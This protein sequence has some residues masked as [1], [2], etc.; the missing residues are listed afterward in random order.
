MNRRRHRGRHE[1][2]RRRSVGIEG[3]APTTTEIPCEQLLAVR[4]S[5][6]TASTHAPYQYVPSTTGTGTVEFSRE[7][8]PGLNLDTLTDATSTSTGVIVA[9]VDRYKRSVVRE[10]LLP[11]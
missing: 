9:S 10:A 1:R 5:P 6:F 2:Q 4:D 8:A 7:L 3:D 11:P